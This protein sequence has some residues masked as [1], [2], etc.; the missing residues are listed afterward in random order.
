MGMQLSEQS[1]EIEELN[2][3]YK[4]ALKEKVTLYTDLIDSVKVLVDR[5]ARFMK[6]ELE[7]CRLMNECSVMK[8]EL[9]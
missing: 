4:A 2:E 9:E 7:I 8:R 6:N 3:R 1:A 5:N